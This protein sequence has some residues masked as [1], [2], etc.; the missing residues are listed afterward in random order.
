MA[1]I[2]LVFCDADTSAELQAFINNDNKLYLEIDMGDYQPSYI[3]LDLE[4]AKEL[5]N[6]L[7]KQINTLN[8]EPFI[9]FSNN[10][11]K[12]K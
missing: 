5:L 4:T 11:L 6:H 2:K 7:E 9:K 3:C 12:F 1:N 10:N 8:P